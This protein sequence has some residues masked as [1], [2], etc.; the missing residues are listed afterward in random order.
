M[1]K[2][3]RLKKERKS[4]QV[5]DNLGFFDYLASVNLETDLLPLTDE[6]IEK[7]IIEIKIPRQE[8]VEMARQGFLYC[9]SRNSFILPDIG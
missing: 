1:G 2:A 4:T 9:T 8:I 5:N 7:L 6:L 3:S